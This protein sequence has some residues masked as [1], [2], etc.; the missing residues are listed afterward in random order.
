MM[1]DQEHWHLCYSLK[2][3]SKCAVFTPLL[4]QMGA[5]VLCKVSAEG[6]VWL[7]PDL[8]LNEVKELSL[9]VLYLLR[10]ILHTAI[11]DKER[12]R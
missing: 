10:E 5:R 12:A 2:G 7:A 6:Q 4:V 1:V 3:E 11:Y 9:D 8:N